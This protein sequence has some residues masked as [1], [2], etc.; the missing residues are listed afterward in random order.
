VAERTSAIANKAILRIQETSKQHSMK[1]HH[2]QIFHTSKSSTLTDSFSY[3]NKNSSDTCDYFEDRNSDTPS[4][5]SSRMCEESTEASLLSRA[6]LSKQ[7]ADELRGLHL[8]LS[9]TNIS[10]QQEGNFTRLAEGK[11]NLD[12]LPSSIQISGN[13]VIIASGCSGAVEMAISVLMNEGDN[14]LVPR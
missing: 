8:R 12:S 5:D 6:N 1:N 2:S 13:D 4:A 9:S 14:I 3:E 11:L 10:A 7:N